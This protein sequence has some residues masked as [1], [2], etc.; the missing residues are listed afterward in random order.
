MSCRKTVLSC[1]E[2]V[3]TANH[4]VDSRHP[5]V[6]IQSSAALESISL[7]FQRDFVLPDQGLFDVKARSRAHRDRATAVP[8]TRKDD[9]SEAR[10]EP[11]R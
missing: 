11:R 10:D 5:P 2:R 1:L 4:D 7:F 3:Q 9:A 8:A 6:A